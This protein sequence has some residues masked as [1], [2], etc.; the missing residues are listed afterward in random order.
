MLLLAEFVTRSDTALKQK[1]YAAGLCKLDRVQDEDLS[2]IWSTNPMVSFF[3][4]PVLY[5]NVFQAF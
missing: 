1:C 2:W 3:E 5:R 4:T